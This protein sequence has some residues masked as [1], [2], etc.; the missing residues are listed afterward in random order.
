[1]T[2][3]P[4]TDEPF[5]E[6]FA[7]ALRGVPCDVVGLGP[8]PSPLPVDHWSRTVTASDRA[9][10]AHC[11]GATLD[12]GCGPGR[13]AAHLA[14]LGRSVLGVDVVEEAI[15]QTRAR[16]VTA[17]RRDVFG[18]LPGEGRWETALLADGNIGIGGNPE[19][20]LRRVHTLLAPRGR[21]VVDLAP[22]GLGIQTASVMLRTAN[23]SSRPFAWTVVGA[24]AIGALAFA[25]D[26]SVLATHEYAGRWFAVLTREG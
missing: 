14:E 6:V 16:G 3:A 4:L 7:S 8:D 21:V 5:T 1:M 10:L 19:R 20:L 18:P 12:I 25:A 22:Y 24:E 9:V 17:L 15:E 13:M 11:L 2:T 23:Q 26:L